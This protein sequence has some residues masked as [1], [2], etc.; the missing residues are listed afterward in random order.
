MLSSD[1][2][3]ICLKG[4]KNRMRRSATFLICMAAIIV[5]SACQPTPVDNAVINKGE[6]QLEEKIEASPAVDKLFEAPVTLQID[7]FGTDEFQVIVD[8]DVVVPETMRYPVVEIEQRDF[9]TDW[10]RNLMQV[11]SGGKPI[12]TYENETPQTKGEI[13][14]E[15][16]SLQD[17][18][19]NPENYLPEGTSEEIR[20]ESISEWQEL[21]K[22]WQEAYQAAPDVFEEQEIDLSSTSFAATG[23]I[24]GAVD[25]G[26]SRKAYLTINR[27]VGGTGG[28]VE[29]NNLD[30]GVGLPFNFDLD[31][32]FTHMN[33]IT[34]S[35]EEAVQIGLNY[36][37]KLGETGFAPS[38]ILAGYCE[39]RG[40]STSQIEDYPQCYKIL[41]TRSVGDAPT[42]YR[43]SKY[44]LLMESPLSSDSSV[45]EDDEAEEQYAPYCPQEYIEMIIRDS[46]VNYMY[47]E[48]PSKQTLILN[49]NVELKSFD[50][51]IERFKTQILYESF[52]SLDENDSVITKTLVIDRIELGMMQVR[53]KDSVATLMMVPTWTFFGKTI[54]KYT[55]QQLGGYPLDEN[56][57]YTSEIPGYSY[58]IINAI[59]GSIVNPVLGY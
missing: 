43:E 24:T 1:K 39:P 33:D 51:I 6:G 20:S 54:L 7:S 17:M 48:M 57:E 36:I 12:F 53:K 46:G 45:V 16:T 14:G 19:A 2:S 28:S 55:E 23:Q 35:K 27:M 8:A 18:L 34:I 3:R 59:D 52:P 10:M 9:T 41:F 32:D 26:K 38:L 15:I 4:V 31:S 30:D 22:A 21:M 5:L 37:E 40:K 50:E 56:N 47:W 25:F 42:T 58:L 49:E 11:M 44:D 29:F 13:L